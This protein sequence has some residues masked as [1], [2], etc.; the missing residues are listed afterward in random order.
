MN[1]NSTG[2]QA[3]YVVTIGREFGCGAR[4]IGRLVAD[5]LG[6]P[7]YDKELLTEA[8]KSSGVCPDVFESADERTPHSFSNL[9]AF[10]FGFSGNALY[11][12]STPQ[13][14][15][16]VYRAQSE[17]I[18]ELAKRGPCVIVGR[19]ADFILRNHTNVISVFIRDSPENR[20]ERM[21]ARGDCATRDEAVKMTQKKN[22]QRADYYNFYTG[23][24]WGDS[25]SYDLCV[26]VSKLGVDATARLI[27]QYIMMRLS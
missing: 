14:D 8:A 22:Q 12:G 13:A 2:A 6:I 17:V 11:V 27:A 21:I 26:D 18:V 3:A 15:D 7:Y 20:V 4:E 1:S 9:L 23:K 25:A 16:S 10:N 5:A 24:R 19:T